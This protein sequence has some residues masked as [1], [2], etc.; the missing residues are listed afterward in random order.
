LARLRLF[1]NL[2]LTFLACPGTGC[3][4][5][6]C[7]R[8]AADREGLAASWC[9]VYGDPSLRQ[10]FGSAPRQLKSGGG[11]SSLELRSQI[12]VLEQ[13]SKDSTKPPHFEDKWQGGWWLS[14]INWDIV[15]RKSPTSE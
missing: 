9:G 10:C 12:M 2:E 7:G 5:V 8:V 11:M 3:L 15:S 13:R 4:P 14:R 6:T 1:G